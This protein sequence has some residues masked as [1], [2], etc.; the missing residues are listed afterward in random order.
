M[1]RV[2][3][4][5]EICDVMLRQLK[6]AASKDMLVNTNIKSSR[7]HPSLHAASENYSRRGVI[8]VRREIFNRMFKSFYRIFCVTYQDI[9]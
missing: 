7:L 8:S 2:K 5:K 3:T 9:T 1:S 4:I 6:Q